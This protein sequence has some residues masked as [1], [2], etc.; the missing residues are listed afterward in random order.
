MKLTNRKKFSI[1]LLILNITVIF[2]S[3]CYGVLTPKPVM[4]QITYSAGCGQQHIRSGG[5]EKNS[6]M[7]CCLQQQ[8]QNT[9][10]VSISQTFEFNNTIA[11]VYLFSLLQEDNDKFSSP[12]I[13]TDSSPPE[14]SI[15]ETIVIR[16]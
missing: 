11:F 12:R 6:L 16:V 5:V 2:S 8:D 13:E 10:N 3:F 1:A 9:P 15:L 4:A 14:K 7:P